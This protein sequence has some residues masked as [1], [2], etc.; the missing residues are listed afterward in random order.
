MRKSKKKKAMRIVIHGVMMM[1]EMENI[2]SN[3]RY[4][5]PLS[6]FTYDVNYTH[7]TQDK[8]PWM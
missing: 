6:L 2:I 8:R 1:M 7:I 5:R 3:S 4:N